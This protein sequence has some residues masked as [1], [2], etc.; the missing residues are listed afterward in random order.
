MTIKEIVARG[1]YITDKEL[2]E[3]ELE[4]SYV[5]KLGLNLRKTSFGVEEADKEIAKQREV[6]EDLTKRINEIS[7]EKESFSKQIEELKQEFE[8]T[9]TV[10]DEESSEKLSIKEKYEKLLND[11]NEIKDYKEKF[12]NFTEQSKSI[13]E[14]VKEYL[15]KDVKED[16]VDYLRNKNLEDII[17]LKDLLVAEKPQTSEDVQQLEGGGSPAKLPGNVTII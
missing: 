17:E 13:E 2:E 5:E 12:A 3:L 9:K 11:Y 7:Q 10:K 1:D 16:K 4:E 15:L 8:S 6:I 14:K